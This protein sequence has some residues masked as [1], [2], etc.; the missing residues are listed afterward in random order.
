MNKTLITSFF[1][2][3]ISIQL[4]PLLI[5]VSCY[6]FL[7]YYS[8]GTLAH[9]LFTRVDEKP[10]LLFFSDPLVGLNNNI[11]RSLKTF[12]L[13]ISL[14]SHQLA[15]H[16]KCCLRTVAARPL[17]IM[18]SRPPD[19]NPR[20]YGS[21]SILTRNLYR[22]KIQDVDHLKQRIKEGTFTESY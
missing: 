11:P 4:L 17:A 7:S 13:K 10:P 22:Q 14:F 12:A 21:C 1:T 3:T 5:I 6:N 20:D 2:C 19:L 8:Q 9:V 18:Q 16:I 15:T